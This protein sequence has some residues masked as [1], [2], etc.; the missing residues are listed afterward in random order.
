MPKPA[1]VANDTTAEAKAI[2]TAKA[3]TRFFHLW[4]H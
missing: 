2:A 3:F 1:A 4:L